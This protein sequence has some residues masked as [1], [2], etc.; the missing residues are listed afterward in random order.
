M[1]LREVFIESSSRVIELADPA[2]VNWK[3][4]EVISDATLTKLIAHIISRQVQ[5]ILLYEKGDL[6]LT[7]QVMINDEGFV[8]R[9]E[10]SRRQLKDGDQVKLMLL[11]GGG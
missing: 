6:D 5:K 7:I 4:D 10:Y 2:Q 11:V 1:S 9:E 3:K 8:P